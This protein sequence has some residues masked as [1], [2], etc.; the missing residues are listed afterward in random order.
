M[1]NLFKPKRLRTL[2]EVD[3]MSLSDAEKLFDEAVMPTVEE[4][5]KP[6]RCGKC[7][8]ELVAIVPE[9]IL[10]GLILKECSVCHERCYAPK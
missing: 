1:F 3:S 6:K 5:I 8:G 4:L 2:G 10:V 7:D 9:V